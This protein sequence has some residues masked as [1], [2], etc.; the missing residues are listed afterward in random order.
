MAFFKRIIIA[1]L[2]NFF[3][4]VLTF[5]EGTRGQEEFALAYPQDKF[6]CQ[7]VYVPF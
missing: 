4:V 7:R 1:S 5:S 6:T 2:G 3:G